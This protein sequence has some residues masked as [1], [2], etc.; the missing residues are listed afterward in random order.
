MAK[1]PV[2]KVKFSQERIEEVVTVEE[3]I[4]ALS[5]NFGAIVKIIE[6]MVIDEKGEYVKDEEAARLIKTVTIGELKKLTDG[7]AK[8][9]R[10]ALVNPTSGGT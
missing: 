1:K 7:I 3:F 6:K 4:G 5:G 8:A 2:V 10:D 9:L